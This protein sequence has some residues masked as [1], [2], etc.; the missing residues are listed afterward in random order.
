M[1]SLKDLSDKITENPWRGTGLVFVTFSIISGLTYILMQWNLV[2]DVE[3]PFFVGI[4]MANTYAIYKFTAFLKKHL[5]LASKSYESNIEYETGGHFDTSKFLNDVF[6]PLRAFLFGFSFGLCFFLYS[7][8][9]SAWEQEKLLD[10]YLGV[11]MLCSNVVT[12]M[13]LYSLFVYFKYSIRIGECVDIDLWDRSNAAVMALVDTNRYVVM[14]TAFVACIGTISIIFSKFKVDYSTIFFSAGSICIIF[15]AYVVPLIPI[16]TKL[17]EK[18]KKNLADIGEMI[19]SEYNDIMCNKNR[20]EI[21][22]NQ[23]EVLKQLHDMVKS[24]RAFPPIGEQ[25]INT[26]ISVTLLTLLPPLIDF[27]L[28]QLG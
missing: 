20:A 4:L 19:Q 1:N 11:F 17:R 3:D 14:A 27:L 28:S 7:Y 8:F 15:L 13:G 5:I 25:S 18:K 24:V 26:A 6:N 10:V 16:T 12:G 21:H 9:I 2:Q 23:L 22:L